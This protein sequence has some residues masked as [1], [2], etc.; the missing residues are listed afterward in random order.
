MPVNERRL[1]SVPS[2]LNHFSGDGKSLLA[3][4]RM[5]TTHLTHL[6]TARNYSTSLLY[7]FSGKTGQINH[8]NIVMIY[9]ARQYL[10]KV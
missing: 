6:T 7:V 3:I 4:E 1:N 9:T 8:M 5:P 2:L 10:T